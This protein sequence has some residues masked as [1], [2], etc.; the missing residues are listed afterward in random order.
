LKTKKGP[1][2]ASALFVASIA[3]K[4]DRVSGMGTRAG[5]GPSETPAGKSPPI[6]RNDH[7]QAVG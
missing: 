3:S 2:I 1:K 5:R 6:A 4:P 7:H